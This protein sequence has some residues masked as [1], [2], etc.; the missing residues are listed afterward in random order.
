MAFAQYQVMQCAMKVEVLHDEFE[1]KVTSLHL[2]KYS[3]YGY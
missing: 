1:Q 2:R 3:E